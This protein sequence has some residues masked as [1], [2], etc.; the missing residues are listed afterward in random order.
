MHRFVR[1]LLVFAPI[2]LLCSC[3]LN[4]LAKKSQDGTG[5][6]AATSR[7]QQISQ[8]S[9]DNAPAVSAAFNRKQ[10]ITPAQSIQQDGMQVSYS[11]L[12]LPGR[13]GNLVR[14]SLVFRNQQ[15]QAKDFPLQVYL[16][17]AKGRRIK[18]YS[19]RGFIYASTS[20]A[21]RQAGNDP[22]SLIQMDGDSQHSAQA[23]T[24]WANSYWLKSHY[25]IPP[26]GIAIGELVY[27]FP[28][29]YLPL[30]L[31]VIVDKQKFEF[32]TR[33]DI[34]VVKRH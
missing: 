24:D 20:K 1:S 3:A 16:W 23:L 19:K 30:K 32:N 11:M 31:Q 8:R 13:H 5:K 25:R 27:L 28:H 7:E 34:P 12:T 17:D 26:H 15:A 14:L 21:A 9:Q 2:L 33:G 29:I 18:H 22:D 10:E 4:P 6:A